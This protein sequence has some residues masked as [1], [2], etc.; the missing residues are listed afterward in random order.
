MIFSKACEYGIKA[1]IYIA[2]QSIH[3]YRASLK[4]ISREIESPEAFTAK[5]LQTLVRGNIITSVKGSAG[6]FEVDLK[7]VR[8]I[9][10][11][12]IVLAIDGSLH[13]GRCVLGLNKCS[14][15]KPCPVH[16]KYKHIK[17]D[18]ISMLEKSTLAEMSNSVLEG[19]ACLRN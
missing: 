7:K 6:G 4:D 2:E 1:A 9:R 11:M 13:E 5:I 17:R 3:G 14:E 10:L 16:D 8:K 19:M 15:V 12:E 18:I